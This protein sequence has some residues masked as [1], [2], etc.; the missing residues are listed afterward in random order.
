MLFFPHLCSF[1]LGIIEVIWQIGIAMAVV[2]LLS[3]V[4]LVLV[5]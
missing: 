2:T 5:R 4:V 1:G 3:R